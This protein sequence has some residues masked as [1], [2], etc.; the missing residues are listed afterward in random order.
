MRHLA[1]PL[2]LVVLLL[3]LVAE[4]PPASASNTWSDTDPVIVVVTPAG[5]M[6]TVYVNV[7]VQGAEHLPSAQAASMKYSVKR[8]Q[9]GQ[10]TSV[11]V[12]V[13]VTCDGLGSPY[14]TR[15]YP[16]SA[17]FGTGIPYGSDYGYC[18]QSM[19]ETFTVTVP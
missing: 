19:V 7:G 2:S 16:S 13:L 3:V 15:I 18:G 8:V 12:S 5:N 9:A 10:A 1:R 17:P 4:A 11:T 14:P 6:V